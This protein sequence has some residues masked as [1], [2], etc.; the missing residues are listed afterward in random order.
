[1]A[2]ATTT[3]TTATTTT[4]TLNDVLTALRAKVDSGD[5]DADAS[6]Q[7]TLLVALADQLGDA[8]VYAANEDVVAQAIAQD[9]H[10]L[11][12]EILH[13]TWI[14]VRADANPVFE[15]ALLAL[16]RLCR[17]ETG[18]EAF[19][20][21]DGMD[22]LLTAMY[23][24]RDSMV[25][26]M[27]CSG[28][29]TN[30]CR[31]TARRA[32]SA[33]RGAIAAVFES[34]RRF[35]GS[36]ADLD[37]SVCAAL[38]NFCAIC[39]DEVAREARRKA[40]VRA[41]GVAVIVQ[42]LTTHRAPMPHEKLQ[43]NACAALSNMV[44][45]KSSTKTERDVLVARA[46]VDA[47]A[48][49][50][51]VNAARMVDVE[52]SRVA[53]EALGVLALPNDADVRRAYAAHSI[54]SVVTETL[55][56]FVVNYDEVTAKVQAVACNTLEI[57][58]AS[59]M[60]EPE[61]EPAIAEAVVAVLRSMLRKNLNVLATEQETHSA[62]AKAMYR[63]FKTAQILLCGRGAKSSSAV[64]SVPSIPSASMSRATTTALEAVVIALEMLRRPPV[65]FFTSCAADFLVMTCVEATNDAARA[66]LRD[67]DGGTAIVAALAQARGTTEHFMQASCCLLLANCGGKSDRP[68]D[69]AIYESVVRAGGIAHVFHVLR[70]YYRAYGFGASKQPG[71]YVY[72]CQF[73]SNFVTFSDAAVR[74]VFD[75]G[76]AEAA[77][78]TTLL[79]ETM[80]HRGSTPKVVQASCCAIANLIFKADNVAPSSGGATAV[81]AA[82][83]AYSCGNGDDAGVKYANG[84]DAGVKYANGVQL[85]LSAMTPLDDATTHTC[86][87]AALSAVVKESKD[88][89]Q[90]V[91]AHANGLPRI[92]AV[93]ARWRGDDY[94]ELQAMRLF[95]KL[96]RWREGEIETQRKRE[97]T[98]VAEGVAETKH[99]DAVADAVPEAAE[100]VA[101]AA[102]AAV[103]VAEAM[104]DD[105][106]TDS[107]SDADADADVTTSED[108]LTLERHACVIVSSSLDVMRRNSGDTDKNAE[109][110]FVGCTVLRWYVTIGRPVVLHFVRHGGVEIVVAAMRKYTKECTLQMCSFCVL[111]A[112]ARVST[113]PDV[114]T[115]ICDAFM[116][117]DARSAVHAAVEAHPTCELLRKNEDFLLWA[118]SKPM[119]FTSLRSIV[120]ALS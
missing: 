9:A 4:A 1:M 117:T 96:A 21:I 51:I 7:V 106:D 87:M 56:R 15:N 119:D 71:I 88:A 14:G 47:G 24:H 102:A 63:A 98:R 44:L 62:I 31:D 53:C 97:L 3:A 104:A 50:L 83:A 95:L 91:L 77:E 22:I 103:A 48:L 45:R 101:A 58:V 27:H 73:F 99:A 67:A 59:E 90:Q 84:D 38:C 20:E 93:L 61:D 64:P 28:I 60:H 49:P 70:D 13:A 42:A 105:V 30:M 86:A 76:I 107:D 78:L 5:V 116:R 72:C 32:Y 2:T 111:I 43:Y 114:R 29:L 41:G 115:E 79:L 16:R 69:L 109:C 66:K 57:V 18:C 100:A 25:V 65:H 39:T 75:M 46:F 82:V 35:G 52:T 19:A 112:C 118:C 120:K 17:S 89:C 92:L 11:L 81:A 33:E 34:S 85:L 26:Q 12:V 110:T 54:V 113:A 74:A 36:C 40:V 108:V 94:I 55:Q 10:R 68:P 23:D 8:L 80:A 37:A 6:E